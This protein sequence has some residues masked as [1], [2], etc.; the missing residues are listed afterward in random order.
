MTVVKR[1]EIRNLTCQDNCETE[2]EIIEMTHSD[3]FLDPVYVISEERFIGNT[4]FYVSIEEAHNEII[5]CYQNCGII[6][7]V[8]IDDVGY[9]VMTINEHNKAVFYSYRG[10]YTWYVKHTS[11]GVRHPQDPNKVNYDTL[12]EAKEVAKE[13][14]GI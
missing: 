6:Q 1:F 7:E 9:G 12:E 11:G 13:I 10:G 5:A 14:Y 8:D 3:G 4:K 2:V